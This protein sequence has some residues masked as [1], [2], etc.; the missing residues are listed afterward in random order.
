MGSIKKY[1]KE[2]AVRV[3]RQELP[4]VLVSSTWISPI[5][6]CPYK[7]QGL[8]TVILF[9]VSLR[10][11]EKTHLKAGES[12]DSVFIFLSKSFN[13]MNITFSNKIGTIESILCEVLNI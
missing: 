9:S 5:F 13:S 1:F 10:Q 2:L 3:A 11:T 8:R 6:I 4:A 7:A 12:L